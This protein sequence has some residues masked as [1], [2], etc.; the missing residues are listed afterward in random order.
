MAL[1]LGDD[2]GED[3]QKSKAAEETP[4]PE[5]YGHTMKAIQR[6]KRA[7]AW[8]LSALALSAV[9]M[10]TVA[11]TRGGSHTPADTTGTSTTVTTPANGSNGTGAGTNRPLDPDAG[12]VDPNGDAG[13]PP[14]GTEGSSRGRGI[15]P[16]VMH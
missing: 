5:R 3:A 4:L 1:L 12:T 16:R 11:C 13:D 9:L 8:S 15:M 2:L 6:M 10:G 7:A 14:A